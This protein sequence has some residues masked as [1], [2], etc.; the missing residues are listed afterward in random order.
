METVIVNPSWT[1]PPSILKKEFL[2]GLASDPY[3][4]E[5]RGFR[6]VRRG[7]TIS[8]QQPP[9]ERNALGYIK[10]IFPNSHAVYLHDTPSRNLFSKE[11]RAFSHGCVRVDQPFRLAEEILK[12]EG[13]WSEARLRGLIGKGERYINLRQHLPVHLTYFT[14]AFDENGRLQSFDDLY[15]FNRKV[16]AALGYES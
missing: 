13:T 6:V 5:R 12:R 14:L 10:F 8:V 1:V 4:A 16:R 11:R 7:N 3:Y 2:P 9:G 15:G